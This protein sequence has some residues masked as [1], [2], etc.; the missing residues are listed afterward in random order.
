V[1]YKPLAIDRATPPRVKSL[2]RALEN[3]YLSDVHTMLR[4][5]DLD[6]DLTAGCNFAITQVLAATVSGISVTLYSHTGGSG[7]RFKGLLKDYYP[8]SLEPGNAVTPQ[9]GANVIYSVIRNPLTH[10]LGM[11]L[12]NKRQGQK[13]VIKRL[14]TDN[15]RK[16]LPEKFIEQLESANRPAPMSPTVT[17]LSGK[18]VVLVEAFYWGLRQMVEHLSHEASRMQSAEAFLASI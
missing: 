12:E 3:H 9:N 7:I 14:G 15:K 17:V 4:L 6:Q 13:I 16:G 18:T 10:D 2:I 11:D 8:W 5:P 1:A